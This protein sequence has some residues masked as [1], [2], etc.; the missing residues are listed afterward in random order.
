MGQ[1]GR[2]VAAV[3][4]GGMAVAAEGQV[5]SALVAVPWEPGTSVGGEVYGFGLETTA[6]GPG[7]DVDLTRIVTYGRARLDTENPG[8]PAFGWLHDHTTIGGDDPLLPERLV[9]T[10]AAVGKSFG[11]YGG[12]A[13]GGSVGAGFA[14]DLP[15]ADEDAW[16]GVASVY[17]RKQLDERSF[18]TLVLDYD[19]SRAVLPDVP[20][21]GIQYTV[22]ESQSLRYSVGVPFSTLHYR[23]D[24]RW[25]FD[26][27]YALPLGGRATVDY[28]ISERWTAF[29]TYTSSTRGYHI[30]GDD[31]H[32]RLF[33]KQD[34]LEAGVRFSPHLGWQWTAAAG[35]AFNQEFTRG[36]DIRHDDR[37]RELDD[38]AYVRLGLSFSF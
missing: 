2:I 37:V 3:V 14:G 9:S 15:F 17:G 36:F 28:K 20:L 23:P 35:W 13:V 24:D 27:Q 30:D 5:G 29:G 8:S 11:D 4:A 25:T 7:F 12:W 10:A 38:A 34:R 1:H 33:L 31:E 6:E 22:V 21:P 19:G 16:F 32:R 18:L 26:L